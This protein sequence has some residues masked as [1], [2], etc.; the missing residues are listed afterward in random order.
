MTRHL[1]I[2]ILFFC[3]GSAVGQSILKKADTHFKNL[4]YTEAAQEYE[5]YLSGKENPKSEILLRAAEANYYIGNT[6]QALF[7]YK[8][9]ITA[10]A[11]VTDPSI[12]RH[13]ILTLRGEEQYIGADMVEMELLKNESM[14][15]NERFR[16]Q[17]KYLDSLNTT[18]PKFKITNLDVN[19]SVADF[20]TVFYKDKVVYASA[21]DSVRDGKKV[22]AWNKQPYLELY[23]AERDNDGSLK[24]E[25]KFLSSAQT[26]YHNAAAAFL[27]INKTVFISVNNVGKKGRL[28]NS[29]DG[30][31]NIQLIYGTLDGEI[32]TKKKPAP[33]NSTDYSV[34]QP[35]VSADGNWLFFVSDMPGGFGGTDIYRAPLYNDGNI[36]RP[37]NLGVTINTHGNE[38]FPFATADA[39]YF[40][41]NGHY[42]LGGLDV[43]ISKMEA[44]AL[45]SPQN[46]KEGNIFSLPQN[47]GRPINSNRDDFSYILSV[48][49]TYGYLSSNRAGGKGDDDIYYFSK[50]TECGR[51]I[52][53]RVTNPKSGQPVAGVEIKAQAEG[54]LYTD[55][56]KADG[57]YSITVPCNVQVSLIEA[58]KPG[59]APTK[60]DPDGNGNF[61]MIGFGDL[62][63]QRGNIELIDINPI[64]FDF[65]QYYITP[66]AAAELDKVVFVMEKF[67]DVVIKIESHTDSR[68]KDDYNLYLSDDRAKSTYS[69]IISK[70][71]DPKRIESVKG[72]GETRLLNMCTNGVE[73]TE[74]AHQLNRRSDFIIVKK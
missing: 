9:Y 28:T 14:M 2:V 56:S 45:T 5:K 69:Y 21:K 41:S 51:L 23:V 48:D 74:E 67:P 64:Y 34:G 3:F 11:P 6:R 55:T 53:G 52:A 18:E 35:A 42:G 4:A 25:K 59:Y 16:L 29:K 15:L 10:T 26:G 47:L 22:Y 60:V 8:Q 70:G 13:Y 58:A 32:L 31:N 66:Q 62:V 1:L 27:P 36:G 20:G 72:Y 24:N 71:I 54:K 44:D 38:M 43:F 37:I 61:D 73:C 57:S 39:L 17:K 49:G 19:T 33:F 7:Y 46:N 40:S 63:K 12:I 50:D 30:T 68:G 65:D